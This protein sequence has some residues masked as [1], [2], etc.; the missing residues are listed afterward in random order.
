[1]EL[2]TG[3]PPLL[4]EKIHLV[5]WVNPLI[6][7]GNIKDLVDSRLEGKY[8]HNRAWKVV[9]LAI[10]CVNRAPTDRPTMSRVLAELKE[11]PSVES[12]R[13]RAGG[14]KRGGP[15]TESSGSGEIGNRIVSFTTP[16]PIPR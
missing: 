4:P 9:S 6:E 11:C 2:V 5:Q 16:G 8:D 15:D 10:E 3:R 13:K 14:S 12:V 7:R 1:M